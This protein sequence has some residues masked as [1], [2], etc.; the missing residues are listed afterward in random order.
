M[1]KILKLCFLCTSILAID[2]AMVSF[3]LDSIDSP[4]SEA[5]AFKI[6]IGHVCV[7][8]FVNIYIYTYFTHINQFCL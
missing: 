2:G 1:V 8:A 7:Y 6:S 3:V 4:L 5:L